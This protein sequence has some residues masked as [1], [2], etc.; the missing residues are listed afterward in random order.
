MAYLDYPGL[1]YFKSLLDETYLRTSY[2]GDTTVAGNVTFT[3][4]TVFSKDITGNINGKAK[5]DWRDQQIDSTYIK[6]ISTNDNVGQI[7]YTKGDNTSNYIMIDMMQGATASAPGKAGLVPAPTISERTKF[8]RGDGEWGVPTDIYVTQNLISTNDSFPIL[9]GAVAGATESQIGTAIAFGT[10]VSVNP[11]THTLIADHLILKHPTYRRSN[12]ISSKVM[13]TLNFADSDDGNGNNLSEIYGY[14]DTPAN[15]GEHELGFRLFGNPNVQG[16]E[17]IFTYLSVGLS[18]TNIPYGHAPETPVPADHNEGTDIITRSY[19]AL[20]GSITGLVHTTMNE[21]IDGTKT[22]VKKI[23]AQDGMNATG[24]IATDSLTVRQDASV[25]RDLTVTRNETVGG[26]L[27]VTGTSTLDGNVHM[28]HNLDVDGNANVDGTT[29]L[30]GNVH[31]KHD[32]DVDGNLNVDGTSNLHQKVTAGAGLEV[33]GNTKTTTLTVTS[34]ATVGT[35]LGVSGKATISGG[36]AITSGTTTDTLTVTSGATISGG[37]TVATGNLTVT[38]GGVT[39]SNGTGTFKNLSVTSNGTFGGSVTANSAS[40]GSGGI[41]VTG[42]ANLNGGTSTTTFTAST[43]NATNANIKNLKITNGGSIVDNDGNEYITTVINNS[44]I[45]NNIVSALL[46]P[47]GGLQK[48]SNNQISVKTGNGIQVSGGYVTT[49][50]KANGGLQ[51][52]GDANAKTISVKAGTGITVDSKG[53]NIDFA[54]LK[55]NNEGDFY[56]LMED[57]ADA[58]RISSDNGKNHFYVDGTNGNDNTT[59]IVDPNDNTKK[60]L[61][62]DPR[63]PFK[64]IQACINSITKVYN[65]SNVNSYINCQNIDETNMLVLPSFNRTTAEITI[66]AV[67]FDSTTPRGQGTVITESNY[68]A[69]GI[70][71]TTPYVLKI[72]R[73]PTS[74]NRYCVSATGTG[75]WNL[76]NFD[77]EMNDSELIA[78]GGHQAAIQATDYATCTLRLCRFTFNRYKNRYWTNDLTTGQHVVFVNSYALCELHGYLQIIGN[79]VD[80]ADVLEIINGYNFSAAGNSGTTLP[81]NLTSDSSDIGKIFRVTS[82]DDAGDYVW[83]GSSWEKI[84]TN[85]SASSE[86]RKLNAIMIADR[87]TVRV[88][89]TRPASTDEADSTTTVYG[90]TVPVL[91]IKKPIVFSGNFNRLIACNS[92]FVRNKAFASETNVSKVKNTDYRFY[93]YA[94]GTARLDNTTKYGSLSQSGFTGQGDKFLGTDDT[95]TDNTERRSYVEFDTYSWYK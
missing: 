24:N 39:A 22:F 9:I 34:G 57:F 49:R 23:V 95:N 94:G 47:N 81:T 54:A 74:G 3:G 19:L 14:I 58:Q 37:A 67:K 16:V 2:T 46:A 17:E 92:T 61:R 66:R 4:D 1:S 35:T 27:G 25:G 88:Q 26:T 36:L 62:G 60:I 77:L 69:S 30:D 13:Y 84:T 31:M 65:F 42:S 76:R 82:G 55:E 6:S 38:S 59:A 63:A 56:K 50:L 44:S 93:L 5:K 15:G 7:V 12:N 52:E 89:D 71:Y 53:I 21:T 29:T 51:Y 75:V 20:N 68:N 91:G 80:A 86:K 78:S 45:R 8:L 64:T 87:A 70:N 18:N 11:N 73:H 10:K 85:A 48:D 28:L 72:T 43:I 79:D 32:L 33:T 83:S 41:T 90:L 40:I